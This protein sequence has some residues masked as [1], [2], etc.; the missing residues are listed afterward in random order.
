MRQFVL[1]GDESGLSIAGSGDVEIILNNGEYRILAD[2]LNVRQI[3]KNLISV[4][5]VCKDWKVGV[6][7]SLKRCRVVEQGSEVV[8][9]EQT[10]VLDLYQLDCKSKTRQPRLDVNVAIRKIQ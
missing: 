4:R 2:V 3:L 6:E 9:I 10:L 5:Q 7:F 8:V 1:L